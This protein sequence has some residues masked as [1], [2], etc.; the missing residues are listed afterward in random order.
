MN[1]F[2]IT[3][4]TELKNFL[5]LASANGFEF[6]YTHDIVNKK[7]QNLIHKA[8]KLNVSYSFEKLKGDFYKGDFVSFENEITKHFNKFDVNDKINELLNKISVS[9][10]RHRDLKEYDKLIKNGYVDLGLKKRDW[11]LSWFVSV[12]LSK[13]TIKLDVND[14]NYYELNKLIVL[15]GFNFEI[16]Y[17]SEY[18][19]PKIWETLDFKIYKNHTL[20]IKNLKLAEKLKELFINKMETET[21]QRSYLNHLIKK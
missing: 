21:K 10:K 2:N 13:S 12:D 4:E 7:L 15:L 19:E 1:T 17:Y 5:S 16:P 18:S 9:G 14:R 11:K 20:E 6:G 8:N 3:T